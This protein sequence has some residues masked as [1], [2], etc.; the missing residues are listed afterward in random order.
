MHNN[1][2]QVNLNDYNQYSIV[3]TCHL[4]M[5]ENHEQLN[6]EM[7]SVECLHDNNER[8]DETY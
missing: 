4:E 3:Y 1:A 8:T 5:L 6:M 2:Q 7:F